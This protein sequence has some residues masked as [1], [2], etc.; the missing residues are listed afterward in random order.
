M[1]LNF[2]HNLSK[3]KF[4]KCNDFDPFPMVCN[5][6]FLSTPQSLYVRQ[7]SHVFPAH[8]F[9][10]SHCSGHTYLKYKIVNKYQFE[11]YLRHNSVIEVLRLVVKCYFIV[12]FPHLKK[13]RNKTEVYCT[14]GMFPQSFYTYV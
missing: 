4:E 14:F 5:R 7:Q 6:F 2:A 3:V 1:F 10:L 13:P 12:I 9:L 11:Q 8:N